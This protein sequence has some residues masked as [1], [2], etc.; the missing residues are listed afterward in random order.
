MCV[1]VDTPERR[2]ELRTL[3]AGYH[4]WM[5][6]HA[7]G[8]DPE[9]E[10]EGDLQSLQTE[11]AAWAWLAR[12]DGEPVGCVFLYGETDDVAEFKRLWVSPDARG[13][14][15]G[16]QLIETVSEKARQEGYERL[17][18][19]TPPWSER[20]HRLYESMGFE[21]TD[22]YPET[23]LPERLHDMAIFMQLSL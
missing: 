16:Q 21:R 5:D 8:Y 6:D 2:V 4:A 15:L 7:D 22:P 3:L 10:L 20:A 12:R 13:E 17:G 14:G 1:P 19:T 18:L 9:A 11:S 23:R